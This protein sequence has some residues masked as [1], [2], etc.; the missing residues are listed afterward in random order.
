VI[1]QSLSP[2]TVTDSVLRGRQQHETQFIREV[3]EVQA[4]KTAL[5]PRQQTAPVGLTALKQLVLKVHTTKKVNAV[6]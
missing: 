5:I 3:V 4:T 6:R 2:L 1:N